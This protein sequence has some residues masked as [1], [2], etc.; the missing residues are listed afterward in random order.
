MKYG[1]YFVLTYGNIIYISYVIYIFVWQ[2]WI[3]LIQS[4]I[5]VDSFNYL[6]NARTKMFGVVQGST[7]IIA[8]LP[9][10]DQ[11]PIV[12]FVAY[13]DLLQN[14]FVFVANSQI[15]TKNYL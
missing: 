14:K 2:Y 15:T 4:V 9:S 5:K 3:E 10:C 11:L 8:D 13:Y 1:M 6:M 12:F 7:K